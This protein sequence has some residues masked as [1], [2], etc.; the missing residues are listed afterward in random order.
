LKK[1]NGLFE[2]ENTPSVTRSLSSTGNVRVRPIGE[3]E[4]SCAR[5]V[6]LGNPEQSQRM[7]I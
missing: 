4:L 2:Q 7:M 6:E 1:P 5:P 3:T